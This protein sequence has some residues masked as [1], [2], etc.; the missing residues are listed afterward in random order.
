MNASAQAAHPGTDTD[1][2]AASRRAFDP[3]EAVAGAGEAVEHLAETAQALGE[4][5]QDAGRMGV[6]W[7]DVARAELV[8]A[9]ISAVRLVLGACFSLVLIFAL[10]LFSCL[11]LGYW[12]AT[13][14]QR[15]DL[16]MALV[17]VFNLGLIVVMGFAIRSWGRAMLMPRSRA[18]I[19]SMA[20]AWS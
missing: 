15:T 6:A 3:I 17:A 12:L 11:A 19:V 10:W 8:V 20:K 1:T 7:A 18:A 4:L 9:R 14:V 16:A 13:I 5:A 2:P